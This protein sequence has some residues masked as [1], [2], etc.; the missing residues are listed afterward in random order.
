MGISFTT[1]SSMRPGM[2][3]IRCASVLG[4]TSAI[5]TARP[6]MNIPNRNRR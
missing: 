2:P 4:W 5:I 1:W 3:P 6:G